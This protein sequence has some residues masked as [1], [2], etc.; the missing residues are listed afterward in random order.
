[1]GYAVK[2]HRRLLPLIALVAL[3]LPIA[4][5]EANTRAGTPVFFPETGHTLGYAF[6]AFFDVQGGLPVLGLPLTEVFLEDGRPVQYFERARLEWHAETSRVEAGHLG[7]WAAERSD[8]PAFASI[9]APPAGASYFPEVG[10]SLGGAFLS[11]WQRNGGLATFGFPISEPFEEQN[12]NDGLMYTVQYFERSR[13]EF[14]PTEQP[15]AQVQLSHLGRLYLA[16]YPA[17]EWASAPVQSA[18]Q[19]WDAVR[20]SHIAIPRIGVNTDIV[21]TGY[22]S[23]EWDVPRYSAAHYWPIGAMPGTNGNIVIAGH[24]GYRG[25]IFSQL[26]Q[27]QTGDEI[28]LRVGGG[29]RRYQVREVLTLLPTEVW[30]MQHTAEETLTLITCVPIGIYTH[31]LIVRATPIE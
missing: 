3:L 7:R 25:I 5:A 27:V 17:P 16:E 2:L 29:E 11:F 31:R 8:S 28:M 14:H 22:S 21:E 15:N 6:R 9:G 19:A 4:P 1:M 20:P 30:V 12:I 10:H 18:K 23:Q 26:P 24:V 13:F